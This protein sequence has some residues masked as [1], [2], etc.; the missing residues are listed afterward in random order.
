MTLA[1]G[2]IAATGLALPALAEEGFVVLEYRS[3]GQSQGGYRVQKGDTLASIVAAQLGQVHDLDAT[4]DMIVAQN[5]HAFV[6]ADPNRLIAGKVLIG[7]VQHS[8]SRR[9]DIYFF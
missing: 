7:A 5:P 9:D 8:G 6:Q 3:H 1:G 4:Y 2:L